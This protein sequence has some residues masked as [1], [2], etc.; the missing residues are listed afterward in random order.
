MADPV[1]LF[2]RAVTALKGAGDIAQG[3]SKLNTLA[4]VQS[5]A[6]ELQQIILAAQASAL[7]AQAEQFALLDRMRQLE[8]EL[9]EVKAWQAVKQNYE[10]KELIPGVFAYTLKQQAGTSEP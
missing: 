2:Q 7:A 5:K 4:E 8:K 10:L 6:V 9:T 1:T 3:L